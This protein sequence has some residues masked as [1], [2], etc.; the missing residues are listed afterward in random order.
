[1]ESAVFI[2]ALALGLL[3]LVLW[4]RRAPA[5]LPVI[6]AGAL[7]CATAGA[8]ALRSRTARRVQANVELA[9]LIPRQVSDK[10]FVTSDKCRACHPGEYATW[11]RTY[12]RTM[13]Q[14]ASPKTV[15]APF[16]DVE[17][18]AHGMKYR[19]HR[20]G[21][22]FRVDMP[23]PIWI[24]KEIE[25]GRDPSAASDPPRVN[26][27]IVLTTGSH[28]MQFYWFET[29]LGRT[30]FQLP[31]GF[32]F[33]DDRWVT[34]EHTFIQP[35][36]LP[37]IFLVWNTSCIKCHS[38]EGRPR[39]DFRTGIS[40]AQVAEFGIACEACHGPAEE[41]IRVNRDPQRRYRLHLSG[42]PDPTIVNPAR[43]SPKRSAEVCGRCHSIF[44]PK[45]V[46]GY[47][48]NG[49][50]YRPGESLDDAAHM[51][52]HP[53]K[54]EMEFLPTVLEQFPDF[55]PE[56]YWDD[57][58]VRIAG[59]DFSAMR[60]SPCYASG[61]LSCLSCHSMHDADP[62]DMLAAGRDED[63]A[64]LQCH[65]SYADRIP[66]HTRHEAGSEGSKCYNC[67]MPH[68]TYGLLKAIRNHEID[69]PSAAISH[70][71]GRPNACNLCH[72]DKT[73]AWTA[74]HLSDWYGQQPVALDDDER[75]VAAGPLLLLR[76]AA[77]QRALAAWH[78]GWGPAQQA[79]GRDWLAPYLAE[80]LN[81]PYAAVRF[82]AKRSLL[83]LPGFDGFDY[84][85]LAPFEEL[86]LSRQY[87]L[88]LWNKSK[89]AKL[90]RS[91]PELLIDS[92][93]RVQRDRVDRL[94]GRRD[95]RPVNLLE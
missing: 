2:A 14:V 15:V 56:R 20:R 54:A 81:D 42:E 51:A 25:L 32:L 30:L 13:T 94:L 82:V 35:P 18:V 45:S 11:H 49:V 10:R 1:M 69:S 80:L 27:R 92:A 86:N 12:H 8:V 85:F 73:L 77:G 3:P 22:E 50:P 33:E 40:D 34:A 84:D 91:G 36:G 37:Q 16:D 52:R 59:R 87:A 63:A 90:D 64:C 44:F 83:K 88:E 89:P 23:D 43:L 9:S 47:N 4:W 75:T 29:E 53:N 6:A 58:M 57:G 93:G 46:Q 24:Q 76:G 70:Q 72:L 41:H 17:L 48:Q 21:D 66:E 7:L 74:K 28:H 71:S 78:A 95:N 61:R 39:H 55:L 60:E 79:S 31:F 5:A 26:R 65:E 68:A 67:H 62:N 38:V 19:L